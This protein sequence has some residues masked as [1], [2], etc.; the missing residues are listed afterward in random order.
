[1]RSAVLFLLALAGVAAAALYRVETT[2]I[3]TAA[4]DGVT[5]QTAWR[6]IAYACEQAGGHGD[7]IRL[8]AGTFVETRPSMLPDSVTIM[9]VDTASTRV[10]GSAAWTI[11]G[12]PRDV[13][14][15]RA[16]YILNAVNRK[17][18]RVSGIAFGSADTAHLLHGAFWFFNCA[19]VD[20]AGRAA[21][22]F[23]GNSGQGVMLLVVNGTLTTAANGRTYAKAADR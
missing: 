11:P 7:T 1:M 12:S 18:V 23:S 16:G 3:D 5:A 20:I 21:A 10:R 13:N 15:N 2:G 9:G 17:R 6:T 14:N 22:Y 19:G 8:G 4:R